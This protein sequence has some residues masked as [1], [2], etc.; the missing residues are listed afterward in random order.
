[1]VQIQVIKIENITNITTV[2]VF[3]SLLSQ[4]IR[5]FIPVKYCQITFPKMS[6]QFILPCADRRAPVFPSVMPAQYVVDLRLLASLIGKA[7]V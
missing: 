2:A 5:A 6:Y 1:M 7:A 3:A 4:R